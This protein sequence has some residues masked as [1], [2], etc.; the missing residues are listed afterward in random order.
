MAASNESTGAAPELDI[1][2]LGSVRL[3]RLNRPERKNA[4]NDSLGWAL[5]AAVQQAAQDDAVR[6]VALIGTGDAFCSGVDL[7]G[8]PAGKGKVH[9]PLSQQDALVDDL[10]WIGRLPLAMRFGCDKPIVAGVNGVAVGAGVALAMCADIR[11]CSA[12]ARFHPGYARAGTSP[13]GGMSWTL[14]QA[15]GHERALRFLLEQRMISSDEALQLGIVGERVEDAAFE[16]RF[17][18]YCSQL[19]DV[20]PIAARQTKRLV[21]RAVLST[22][23][24]AHIRDELLYVYRGLRSEDGR[25][26]VSAIRE[27]RKPQ[28]HGR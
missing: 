16:A 27:R 25:E 21:A 11:L 8:D 26:A 2:T 6:V 28:F 12:G 22:D 10:G 3:L 15:L 23:L 4:L 13:D 24:E 5:V 14:L 18:A 1:D 9:G 7:V 20:A 17:F 19:C